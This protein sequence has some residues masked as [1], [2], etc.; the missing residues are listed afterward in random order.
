MY[1]SLSHCEA[2][3]G[4][5]FYMSAITFPK[6]FSTNEVFISSYYRPNIYIRFLLGIS[7]LLQLSMAIGQL[8]QLGLS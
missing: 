4:T 7:F 5:L 1:N 3:Q 6:F 8:K 2:N